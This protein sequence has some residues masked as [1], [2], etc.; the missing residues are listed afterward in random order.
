MSVSESVWK[1]C[2]FLPLYNNNQVQSLAVLS[3]KIHIKTTVIFLSQN[4]KIVGNVQFRQRIL[5]SKVESYLEG[6]RWSGDDDV[7]SCATAVG[8]CR[9]TARLWRPWPTSAWRLPPFVCWQTSYKLSLRS[10]DWSRVPELWMGRRLSEDTRLCRKE[11]EVEDVKTV[12]QNLFFLLRSPKGCCGF[13]FICVYLLH[14][15]TRA[16][17]S[18]LLGFFCRS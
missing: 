15:S 4:V 5:I 7:A 14:S 6:K 8:W 18:S 10:P 1:P 13:A 12:Q 3:H 9:V 11:D 17:L 2:F 16:S